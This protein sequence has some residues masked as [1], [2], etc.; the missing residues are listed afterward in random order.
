MTGTTGVL[1]ALLTGPIGAARACWTTP[2]QS[3]RIPTPAPPHE[4]Y[5]NGHTFTMAT[6]SAPRPPTLDAEIQR[7]ALDNPTQLRSL[8]ASLLD[9]ITDAPGATGYVL[10]E[11]AEKILIV[12][13]EL[14]SNALRYGRPPTIVRLCRTG[15]D[16]IIDVV[17]N[18]PTTQ[19]E[20]PLQRQPASGG[21]GL[22]LARALAQDVGWYVTTTA[23][24]VWARFPAP[25]TDAV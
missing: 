17:D 24:H 18:D 13:T 11:V 8:R 2:Q 7:W 6:P 23:K 25:T 22:V 5:E 12:A 19:P 20:H 3:A 14:A 9:T 16:Y 10:A 21:W 4:R 1:P 15:Q